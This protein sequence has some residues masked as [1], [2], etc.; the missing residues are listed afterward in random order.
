MSRNRNQWIWRGAEL[1]VHTREEE[2][3]D[4]NNNKIHSP[5]NVMRRIG[6]KVVGVELW[7]RWCHFSVI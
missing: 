6:T 7:F 1:R 2:V 3:A 4:N 5:P